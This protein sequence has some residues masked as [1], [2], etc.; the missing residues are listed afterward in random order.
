MSKPWQ[1]IVI[2]V[3][4]GV[5]TAIF[6]PVAIAAIADI[7]RERRGEMMGYFSTAT[8]F[9]RLLAP[10]VAGATITLYSFHGTYALCGVFGVAAL[11]ALLKFPETGKVGS[12]EEKVNT[13]LLRI[14]TNPGIIAAS[15]MMALTYFAMQG[16]ETFLPLYMKVL[17]VE[18]WAHW[19]NTNY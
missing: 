5:A 7:Y 6:T 19:S 10:S 17:G 16:I 14:L 12:T 15:S 18:P 1:L 4:H 9:G 3:Y 13:R 8:L 2:R 11:V